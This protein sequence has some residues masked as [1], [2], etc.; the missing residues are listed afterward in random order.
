MSDLEELSSPES[1]EE[2][3][4]VEDDQSPVLLVPQQ[5]PELFDTGER[6]EAEAEEDDEQAGP[7]EARSDLIGEV[8]G[9]QLDDKSEIGSDSESSEE[10]TGDTSSP[11][12]VAEVGK[13]AENKEEEKGSP[14]I[15]PSTSVAEF[16]K[17]EERD[18]EDKEELEEEEEEGYPPESS[19]VG[20]EE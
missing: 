16:E 13:E 4:R 19:A 8:T 10:E 18:V 5:P 11:P 2:D 12:S 1:R 17:A 20:V 3:E 9:D 7:S 14:P 15:E 6:E